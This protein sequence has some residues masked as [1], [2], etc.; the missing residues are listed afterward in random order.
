VDGVGGLGDGRGQQADGGPGG[1][2]RARPGRAVETDDG[3]EVDHAAQLVLGDL[4]ERDPDPGGKRLVGEPGLSGEGAAQD[5]GEA[6]P[7]LGAQA[8]KSTEPV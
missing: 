4:G 7:Q 2:S 8:L 1:R 3:V 5:D 6:P